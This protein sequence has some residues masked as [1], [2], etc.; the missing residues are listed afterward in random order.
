MRNSSGAAQVLFIIIGICVCKITKCYSEDNDHAADT[1]NT[2]HTPR[3][4]SLNSAIRL[5]GVKVLFNIIEPPGFAG[6]SV[7]VKQR[8][9]PITCQNYTNSCHCILVL[10]AALTNRSDGCIVV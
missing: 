1:S 5:K 9:C 6:L 2:K 7:G 10:P 4:A 3:Q 8:V